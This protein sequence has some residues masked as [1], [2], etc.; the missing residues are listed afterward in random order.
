M[1]GDYLGTGSSDAEG[2]ELNGITKRARRVL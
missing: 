2:V 1:G